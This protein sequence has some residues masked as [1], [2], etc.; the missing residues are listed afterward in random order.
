MEVAEN[1]MQNHIEFWAE[2]E[3]PPANY[4]KL[5]VVDPNSSEEKFV[6]NHLNE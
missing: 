4:D 3:N 2:S 6:S 5:F 1:I